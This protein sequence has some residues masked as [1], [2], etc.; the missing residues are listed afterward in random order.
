MHLKNISQYRSRCTSL[1][2]LLGLPKKGQIYEATSANYL[3][4]S[5]ISL[6]RTMHPQ[7]EMLK[8]LV[9]VCRFK[10]SSPTDPTNTAEESTATCTLIDYRSYLRERDSYHMEMV[11]EP[12]LQ[13]DLFRAS[14]YPL[15]WLLPHV[16][17]LPDETL[18]LSGPRFKGL[19]PEMDKILEEHCIP[20]EHVRAGM[21][22]LSRHGAPSRESHPLILRVEKVNL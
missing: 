8:Q 15:P 2:R 9:R 16:M 13:L 22:L 10:P 18:P 19:I 12:Y 6:L 1:Y 5:E 21:V 7:L 14:I 4:L 3:L 20:R 17:E 11:I